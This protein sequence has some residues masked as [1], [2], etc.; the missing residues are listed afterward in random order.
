[1]AQIGSGGHSRRTEDPVQGY[2]MEGTGM[3]LS[4]AMPMYAVVPQSKLDLFNLA[5]YT[6]SM[7]DQQPEKDP[8]QAARLQ[9]LKDKY[10]MEGMRRSVDAVLLVHQ[11]SHP[12]V[13][14]LQVGNTCFKLP[15]GRCKAD[16]D[17]VTCLKRKL[18][19]K[20]SP[21]N[22]YAQPNWEVGELL[23]VYWRPHYEQHLYPYLPPH[24]T[25]PKECRKLYVVPLPEK[26]IFAVPRNYKLLAV[27]LFELYENNKRY[28]AVISSIPQVLSR[29]H[30][31]YNV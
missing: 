20:L 10:E 17:E 21:P 25:K 27:P 4:A 2:A 14:L 6:F 11:H 8:S 9:R 22:Q 26:C 18:S 16:E 28:G 30:V 23:G 31:N 13:L 29:F 15:G 1:M 3:Q 12:H 19:K 7:K 5:N 24:I